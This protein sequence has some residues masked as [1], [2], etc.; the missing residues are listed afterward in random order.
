MKFNNLSHDEKLDIQKIVTAC[1][2]QIGGKNYFFKMIEDIK[3]LKQHPL[4]NKTGKCHFTN[5]TIVWH[6][7]IY[8]DK[9]VALKNMLI[10]HNDDNLL[11]IKDAKLQKD[12]NNS[13]KTL[14]NIAFKIEVKDQGSYEF[15]PFRTITSTSVELDPIFQII[16]FDS[17]NNTKRIISYK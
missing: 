2:E 5:G 8:K 4:S 14:C 12:V 15:K 7:E 3:E 9:I 6:K 13:I 10:S 11:T 16:F 1:M 17:L